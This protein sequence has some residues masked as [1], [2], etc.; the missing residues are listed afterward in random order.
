MRLRRIA[1]VAATPRG[2]SRKGLTSSDS[3][4]GVDDGV[5]RWVPGSRFW[6]WN[7]YHK[8]VE[9]MDFPDGCSGSGDGSRLRG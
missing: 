6:K 7:R 3:S 8:I 2:G 1:E 4:L 9:N 5:L